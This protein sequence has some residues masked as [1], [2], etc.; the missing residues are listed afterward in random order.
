MLIFKM[1]RNLRPT[2][3]AASSMADEDKVF[4]PISNIINFFEQRKITQRADANYKWRETFDKI[5][6]QEEMLEHRHSNPLIKILV[7]NLIRKRNNDDDQINLL[8][9]RSIQDR[10]N[11]CPDVF[12]GINREINKYKINQ[13]L[14]ERN[15]GKRVGYAFK[16]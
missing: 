16:T 4:A 7:L 13:Q 14:A 2:P 15:L 10:K 1:A 9:L 3:L 11:G 12:T 8:C 6:N 5:I